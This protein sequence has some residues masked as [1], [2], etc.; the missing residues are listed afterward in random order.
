MVRPT[1]IAIAGIHTD[2][3]KTIT[4][5]VLC[6][7]LEADY[8]KPVQAGSLEHTDSMQVQQ[9]LH[10]SSS[11]VHPEALQLQ[12][13]ASPHKAAAAEQVQFDFRQ[14]RLPQTDNLLLVETAGGLLSPLDQQHT[15]ADFIG[16]F[17]LPALLVTRHYLGSINHT[18]LCIENMRQRGLNLL[19][20]VVNGPRDTA[21]EDFIQSYSGG[22]PLLYIGQLPALQADAVAAEARLLR[23]QLQQHLPAYCKPDLIF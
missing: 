15:M 12:L 23:P 22:L 19:A 14:L 21:S 8:W 3:G 6:Q 1:S 5:A 9:L 11:K 13:A 20:L 7:A 17:N 2:I 16:H 10:N 4:S 18:L